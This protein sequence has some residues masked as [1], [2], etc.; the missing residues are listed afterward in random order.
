MSQASLFAIQLVDEVDS[1]FGHGRDAKALGID[2]ADNEYLLKR[3]QDG[4]LLPLTEWL[5]HHLC[6]L[7][8]VPTPEFA[9]VL[10]P[11]GEPAFGSRIDP[12][13]VD[14]NR[15][16]L[17]HAQQVAIVTQA[18]PTESAALMLDAALNNPDRHFGNWL[19]APRR[20]RFV[21][22]AIDWSRMQSLQPPPFS[23]WPWTAGCRSAGTHAALVALGALQAA[24]LRGAGHALIRVDESDVVAIIQSAPEEWRTGYDLSAMV[25]WWRD[26]RH[27]RI[28]DSLALLLP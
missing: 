20:G 3:L 23:T 19:Y 5:C 17:S 16:V 28:D 4:P 11:N 8:G 10:R 22:L 12:N 24:D 26:R 9:V 6:R 18:A 2:A 21:A 27:A 15:S 13:V 1:P 25:D 7:C 14:F